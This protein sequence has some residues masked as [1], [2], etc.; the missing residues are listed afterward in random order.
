MKR[1]KRV[2][3]WVQVTRT[4]RGG[5]YESVVWLNLD[6]YEKAQPSNSSPHGTVL[7]PAQTEEREPEFLREDPE[8]VLGW[9]VSE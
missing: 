4:D 5:L 6:H 2:G 1:L 7:W 3:S 8:E 9:E